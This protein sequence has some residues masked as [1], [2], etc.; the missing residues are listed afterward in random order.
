MQ[1]RIREP[2]VVAHERNGDRAGAGF[3]LR[4]LAQVVQLHAAAAGRN[5]HASVGAGEAHTAAAGIGT[6]GPTHVAKVKVSAVR[7]GT[8][9]AITLAHLDTAAAG[10]D[11][12]AFGRAD[13]HLAATDGH[14]RLSGNVVDMNVTTATAESEV[15]AE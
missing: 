7:T 6:H 10:R 3:H 14:P 4:A 9:V 5:L 11:G 1:R 15:R 2:T 13:V 8:Q 12:R